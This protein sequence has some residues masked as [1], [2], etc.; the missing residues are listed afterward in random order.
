MVRNVVGNKLVK[1]VS[2]S[3]LV[4]SEWVWKLVRYGPESKP[5]TLEAIKAAKI[6]A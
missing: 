3:R 2:H 1:A 5:I 4:K 6:W